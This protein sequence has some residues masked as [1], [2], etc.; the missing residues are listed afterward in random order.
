MDQSLRHILLKIQAPTDDI[1][2]NKNTNFRSVRRARKT[3][4]PANLDKDE[5]T[6][7]TTSS[8]VTLINDMTTDIHSKNQQFNDSLRPENLTVTDITMKKK[9]IDLFHQMTDLLLFPSSR[10]SPN[11]AV[12]YDL[13]EKK[14]VELYAD[15]Q[16]NVIDKLWSYIGRHVS[17]ETLTQI[18]EASTKKEGTVTKKSRRTKDEGRQSSTKAITTSSNQTKARQTKKRTTRE[19]RI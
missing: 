12:A 14:M 18:M 4:S 11:K 9:T 15:S 5:V 1:L 3:C 16:E 7:E 19:S 13:K 6:D 10:N 8:F 17:A 2:K